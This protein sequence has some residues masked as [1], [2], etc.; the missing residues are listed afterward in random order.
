MGKQAGNTEDVAGAEV[1]DQDSLLAMEVVGLR[2]ASQQKKHSIRI[3]MLKKNR[4][5]GA[6][7]NQTPVIRKLVAREIREPGDAL[8][9]LHLLRIRGLWNFD[10]R[11]H[12]SRDA[13]TSRFAAPDRDN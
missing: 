2:D 4:L 10:P 6:I 11:A 5:A 9:H 8:Q 3:A 1:R 12:L 7:A 13:V